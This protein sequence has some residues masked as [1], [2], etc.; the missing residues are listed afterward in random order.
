[1]NQEFEDLARA[2]GQLAEEIEAGHKAVMAVYGQADASEFSATRRE[3]WKLAAHLMG[4]QTG[5][6]RCLRS[7]RGQGEHHTF[8]HIHQGRPEPLRRPPPT[9]KKLKTNVPPVLKSGENGHAEAIQR[10]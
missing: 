6:L 5:A 3:C 10:P 8:T 2:A 9:P 7:L 1:M 4:V